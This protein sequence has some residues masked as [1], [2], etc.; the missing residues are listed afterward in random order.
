MYEYLSHLSPLLYS[1]VQVPRVHLVRYPPSPLTEL[2]AGKAGYL[3]ALG[4]D[5]LQFCRSRWTRVVLHHRAGGSCWIDCMFGYERSVLRFL[6]VCCSWR[7]IECI[8]V[9]NLRTNAPSAMLGRAYS[10]L[11]VRCRP[12]A[13]YRSTPGQAL[14]LTWA[15]S[16]TRWRSSP[17]S[18]TSVASSTSTSSP[19][20]RRPSSAA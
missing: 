7:T 10:E 12:F 3:I 8:R 17:S 16:R 6:V 4:V 14:T 5:S 18:S 2:Q 15:R 1:L 9:G 19:R 11:Q 20:R 13:R